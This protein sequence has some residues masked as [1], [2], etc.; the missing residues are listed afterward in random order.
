MK[1]RQGLGGGSE[2]AKEEVVE[3]KAQDAL[4]QELFGWIGQWRE[5]T[6]RLQGRKALLHAAEEDD[7]PWLE[8]LELGAEG[9]VLLLQVHDRG[10]AED[11]AVD[12]RGSGRRGSVGGV[13]VPARAR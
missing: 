6:I 11:H 8:N 7:G 2:I 4:N 1:R 5:S 3:S 9:L 12:G 13:R 10:L